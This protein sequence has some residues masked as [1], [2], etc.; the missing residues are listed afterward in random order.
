MQPPACQADIDTSLD[1]FNLNMPTRQKICNAR[2]LQHFEW[3][4]QIDPIQ[5]V[6]HATSY[7]QHFS[8]SLPAFRILDQEHTRGVL[9]ESISING[10]LGNWMCCGSSRPRN[11]IVMRAS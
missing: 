9:S 3:L 10:K 8:M 2:N 1:A 4:F 7:L 5:F 11:N 6:L